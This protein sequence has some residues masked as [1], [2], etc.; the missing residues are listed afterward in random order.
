MCFVIKIWRIPEWS[1]DSLCA[2]RGLWYTTDLCQ[3]TDCEDFHLCLFYAGAHSMHMCFLGRFRDHWICWFGT[4]VRNVP[5]CLKL[6]HW[7]AGAR[8]QCRIS[9]RESYRWWYWPECRWSFSLDWELFLLL[10]IPEAGLHQNQRK[11]VWFRL[12]LQC[13]QIQNGDRAWNE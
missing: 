10:N 2:L 13:L 1:K 12:K 6:V 5:F 4:D 8:N 9:R 3:Q 7:K 11:P